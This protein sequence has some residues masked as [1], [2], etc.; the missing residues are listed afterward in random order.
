MAKESRQKQKYLENE[1]SFWHEIKAFFIIFK[2]ISAAK[3]C[4]RPERAPLKNFF[5]AYKPG[6]FLAQVKV[7]V[8]TSVLLIIVLSV[9]KSLIIITII[10]V[11]IFTFTD[12]LVSLAF[13][14]VL[15]F[16][17]LCF[18][19]LLLIK[20]LFWHKKRLAI[21]NYYRMFIFFIVS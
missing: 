3:N 19:F 7:I 2:R 10:S 4:L 18:F 14:F 13:F 9:I 12:F 15:F 11:V 6:Q 5:C 1:K 8:A 16:A 17:L 20:Q 21:Q